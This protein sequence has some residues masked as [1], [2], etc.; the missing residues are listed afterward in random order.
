MF[1]IGICLLFQ[2]CPQRDDYPQYAFIYKFNENQDCSEY[3]SVYKFF[4]DDYMYSSPITGYKPVS[5]H[6][7]YYV[8]G[9]LKLSNSGE[10]TIKHTVYL[11]VTLEDIENGNAP[12]D[13]RTNYM[14]YIIADNPFS[15]FY[16]WRQHSSNEKKNLPIPSSGCNQ[17]PSDYCIDTN[18]L[19]II[20]DKG[21]LNDYFYRIK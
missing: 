13:W 3:Q 6:N 14:Q 8:G 1:V 9:N 21:E 20:I 12:N 16:L 19:N 11:S 2:A 7:G 17:Y 10:Y 5:L 15:E 18:I 4:D